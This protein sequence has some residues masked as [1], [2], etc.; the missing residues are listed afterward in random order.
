[1]YFLVLIGRNFPPLLP[2]KSFNK[3]IQT[4]FACIKAF[5]SPI[6]AFNAS[7][8]KFPSIISMASEKS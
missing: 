1:M 2:I 7:Y 6:N 4:A 5:L 8:L 3:F